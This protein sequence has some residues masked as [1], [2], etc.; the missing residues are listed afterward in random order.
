MLGAGVERGGRFVHHQY[1]GVAVEGASDGDALPLPAGQVVSFHQ[2][3][4]GEVSSPCGSA[5][6]TLSAAAAAA[7]R[8]CTAGATPTPIR[9]PSPV[10][11]AS[12]PGELK[13]SKAA[14]PQRAPRPASRSPS[15]CGHGRRNGQG[16]DT[17]SPGRVLIRS[18]AQGSALTSR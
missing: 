7:A 15:G 12:Q 2:E 18:V 5:A 13:V 10:R 8:W 16:C 3:R 9:G 11:P 14:R 1:R 4:A 6:M 17:A